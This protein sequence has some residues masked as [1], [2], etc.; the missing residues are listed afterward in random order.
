M[1]ERIGRRRNTGK[2]EEEGRENKR[3]REEDAWAR[4]QAAARQTDTGGSRK[5]RHT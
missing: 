1:A 5:V 3:E 2:G 4:S